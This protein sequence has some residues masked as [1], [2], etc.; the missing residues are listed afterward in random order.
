M[1]L[2]LISFLRVFIQY[3]LRHPNVEE[4]LDFEI[5]FYNKFWE[6]EDNFILEERKVATLK[7]K[8]QEWNWMP[9]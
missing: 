5:Y 7:Y 4:L 6:R 8:L 3:E 9:K 2:M 1:Y